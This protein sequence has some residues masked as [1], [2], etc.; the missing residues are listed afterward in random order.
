MLLPD[1]N[2][3]DHCTSSSVSY[4]VAEKG[5]ARCTR[6][7]ADSSGRNLISGRGGYR[8]DP[9]ATHHLCTHTNMVMLTRIS[10][11]QRATI[12][13]VLRKF[14]LAL[15]L[16]GVSIVGVAA[17][18]FKGIGS[19]YKRHPVTKFEHGGHGASKR[20]FNHMTVY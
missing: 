15:V 14:R 7:V 8:R 10:D 12:R 1:N 13:A 5:V 6:T 20:N 16:V 11:G 18:T 2:A 19:V 3:H 9:A 4:K 17:V